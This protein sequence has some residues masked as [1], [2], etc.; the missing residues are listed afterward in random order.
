MTSKMSH[1]KK[2]FLFI[3][4]IGIVVFFVYPF[5]DRYNREQLFKSEKESFIPTFREIPIDFAHQYNKPG[6]AFA[7]GAIIDIDNDGVQEVFVGGGASQ[8]DAL[9][10]YKNGN[11]KN[12]IE[13]AK[14]SKTKEGTYGAVSID[15][16]NDNQIDLFVARDSGIYLYINN[17]G[18]FS[19]RKITVDFEENTIPI[20]IAAGDINKDGFVDLYI[21]VFANLAN[22]KTLKFNDPSNERSNV[23]LLNNGDNTFKDITQ[24]S[25]LQ[26]KKNTFLS[27]FV[28]LDYDSWIDLVVS[29]DTHRVKIY[30]NLGNSTFKE[31]PS[32]TDYGSW[33][34]LGI[35]D[36]DNDADIDL[37][38]TNVGN[39]LPISNVGNKISEILFK[40][41]LRDD[42]KVTVQWALL[43][44][45]GNFTFTD[46]TNQSGLKKNQFAWGSLLEDFN[47]DGRQDLIVAE[48]YI[49]WPTHKFKFFR[50]PGKFF[51]QKNN[52][53]FVSTED[54]SGLTNRYLG[55]SPLVADFNQDGYPDMVYVNL[56]G[57][58]RA[59][60][61]NGGVSNYLTVSLKD[62]PSS[63]GARVVVQKMDGSELTKQFVTSTGLVTDQ[64]PDLFF[65]LGGD[66]KIKS[67]KVIWSSGTTKTLDSVKI[68]SKVFIYE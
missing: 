29:T 22:F 13:S 14:I 62:I 63:I 21:S 33:M 12:I 44:N 59:F 31:M 19:E 66:T 5:L 16:N 35:G 61:N 52:G 65:G 37:F 47:L 45:E 1:K 30:K 64:S 43:R 28:D 39:T 68:N 51:V 58:L 26:F 41:D 40:G 18:V 49:Q 23:M 25:G 56:N 55:Q 2:I 11:F 38:F 7:G 34:G 53:Q 60:I 57:P 6:H 54:I 24:S 17:N 50:A 9:F 20:A 67:L 46:I 48:N 27:V 3:F 42:Q 36:I 8:P 32:P 15:V 10:V 4:F